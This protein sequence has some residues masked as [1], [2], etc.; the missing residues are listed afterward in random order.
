MQT[1]LYKKEIEDISSS[2]YFKKGSSITDALI[3]NFYNEIMKDEE[4]QLMQLVFKP[5]PTQEELDKL[6]AVW[7]IEVKNSNKSLL[8]SYFQ[9]RHPQLQFHD[10]TGP[11]LKGLLLN[12]RFRNLQTIAHFSKIG[13]EL[14]KNE[15]TPMILKGGL[16]KFL[17]PN[18]PRT[19]GDIDIVVPEKDW[20]KS[21]DIAVSLGY[22]YDK[23][24]IHSIDIHEGNSTSLDGILDIHRFIYFDTGKEKEWI[25][26]LFERATEQDVFGVKSLVPCF[27]DLMFITLTNLSRNLRDKTSQAGLLFSL[28]DCKFFL[29][30]KPDFNWNIVK[31]NAQ[32]TGT[33][34]QINFAIKFINKI[35]TD[36]LPQDIQKEMPFERETNDYSRMIMYK[37]FYLEGI[38][39][40]CRSMKIGEVITRPNQ[41]LDYIT[42]KP[43]YFALKLIRKHPVL[44]EMLIRDLKT[45]NYSFEK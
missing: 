36:V 12:Y 42:L 31:D 4:K 26:G 7:D 44:I 21:A 33:E 27:E 2:E 38:R 24:D 25:K 35:S 43:K 22:R 10:Y 9:K 39:T 40:K 34:I 17:R 45:R 13:K 14:N 11:R 6:L 15:I 5:N 29:D 30:N 1:F 18:L 16:M 37:R 23:I 3:E 8:L 20:I 32:K 19:M 41:W 28:F